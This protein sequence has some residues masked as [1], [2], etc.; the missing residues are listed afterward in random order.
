ML[1]AELSCEIDICDN[2]SCSANSRGIPRALSP[3]DPKGGRDVR[4]ALAEARGR[5]VTIDSAFILLH[6]DPTVVPW[7]RKVRLGHSA[8]TLRRSREVDRSKSEMVSL[9]TNADSLLNPCH[10]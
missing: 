9:N 5:R 6:L 4:D 2:H 1:C 8:L 7:G 3:E 10:P